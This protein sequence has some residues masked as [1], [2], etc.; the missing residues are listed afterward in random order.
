MQGRK[1][2]K[3]AAKCP[4]L[5]AMESA[6]RESITQSALALSSIPRARR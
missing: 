3:I 2:V 1:L 6:V 5:W 4:Y